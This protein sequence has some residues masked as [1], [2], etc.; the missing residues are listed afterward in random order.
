MRTKRERDPERWRTETLARERIVRTVM[1]EF[2]DR[3]CRE[4]WHAVR[5]PPDKPP[6]V[7]NHYL[8][9]PIIPGLLSYG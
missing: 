4:G 1:D 7:L 3:V 2:L 6:P 9:I 8:E 5:K